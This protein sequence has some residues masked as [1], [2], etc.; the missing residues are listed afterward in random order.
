MSEP[1]DYI[2]RNPCAMPAMHLNPER[3]RCGR[4]YGHQGPHHD[5]VNKGAHL[6]NQSDHECPA[7]A[8][9]GDGIIYRCMY[10]HE[11]EQNVGRLAKEARH[12][13]GG[14][15]FSDHTSNLLDAELGNQQD[16]DRLRGE[17]KTHLNEA[18]AATA[19]ALRVVTRLKD[20]SVFDIEFAESEGH[21]E[22]AIRESGLFNAA[23]LAMVEVLLK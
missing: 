11:N 7:R 19:H 23:A 9:G 22:H 17:L 14:F 10:N 3:I 4:A 2:D 18:R 5:M 15:K 12:D 20:N 8:R 6:W 13:A 21:I 1:L 16:I